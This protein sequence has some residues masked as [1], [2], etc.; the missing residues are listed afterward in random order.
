MAGVYG[1]LFLAALW[2]RSW[3]NESAVLPIFGGVLLCGLGFYA[4]GNV[5]SWYGNPAYP[6]SLAGLIQAQTVG[7]PGFQPTWTFLRNSWLSDLLF[8]SVLVAAHQAESIVRQWEPLPW[9]RGIRA[10]V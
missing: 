6:Q 3:R 1:G 8:T 10:A 5:I 9:I 2:G 7:L 4:I